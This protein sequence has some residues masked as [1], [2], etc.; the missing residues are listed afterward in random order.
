MMNEYPK[1]ILFDIDMQLYDEFNNKFCEMND[2]L[3]TIYTYKDLDDLEKAEKEKEIQLLREAVKEQSQQI[4]YLNC[5]A[6]SDKD[7]Y[8]SKTNIEN[9]IKVKIE[10]YEEK[11]KAQ[12]GK[13]TIN[14]HLYRIIID[15]VLKPILDKIKGDDK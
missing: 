12:N 10:E 9:I 13:K 11:F 8:I 2:N 7:N 6:E 1:D 5:I 15:E 3:G 14:Y 4:E